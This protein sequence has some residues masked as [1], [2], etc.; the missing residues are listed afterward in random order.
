MVDGLKRLRRLGALSASLLIVGCAARVPAPVEERSLSARHAREA[1]ARPSTAPEQVIVVR[2]DTLYGIAFRHGLDWRDLARWNG[3]G[4]P[5]TIFPGQVLRLVPPERERVSVARAE[6]SP[7]AVTEPRPAR[8]EALPPEP[9]PP[10]PAGSAAAASPPPAVAPEKPRPPPASRPEQASSAAPS[11]PRPA[12]PEP[13]D[14][15]PPAAEAPSASPA[16]PPSASAAAAAET[17]S[18]LPFR[19]AEGIRWTWPAEGVILRSFVAGDP[20]RQGIDIGGK[21][22]DTVRAAAD[23]IVVYS[24]AGLVGYGELVIIKHDDRYLSAYGHNRRRLVA[25]G[26]RVRGGQPIAEMGRTGAE[27]DKLHFEIRRDGRPVDP[28]R[29]LPPR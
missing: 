3:L 6:P 11:E 12:P 20:L 24:G 10:P 22:G 8:R 14:V 5:Y 28:L 27:R 26:E 18:G 29:Y 23:G 16:A 2:G 17:P 15:R 13:Q 1:E 4:E 9:S 7:S 19:L 25:E 21:A